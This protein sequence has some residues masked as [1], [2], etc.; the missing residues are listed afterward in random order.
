MTAFSPHH[1]GPGHP[2]AAGAA[3]ATVRQWLAPE[4][5]QQFLD[6]YQAAI[7]EA[8]SSLGL[9]TVHEVTERRRRLAILRTDPGGYRRRVLR[10]AELATGRPTPPDEPPD[11]TKRKAGL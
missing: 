11:V 7:D 9:T 1:S 4:D 5:A 10:V 3:P 6:E 8:R 2:L